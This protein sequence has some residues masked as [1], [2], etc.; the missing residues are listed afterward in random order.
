MEVSQVVQLA[1][2]FQRHSKAIEPK[3]S[4]LVGVLQNNSQQPSQ[5]PVAEPLRDLNIALK[6][7]PTS[8]LSML[9]LRVL[10][11]L[12]VAELIGKRGRAWLK[13]KIQGTTYD[14]A[15]TF[16]TVQQA[17]QKI[18][19][20][21]RLLNE[22]K[23][24]ASKVGFSNGQAL[25]AP[26]PYVFNVIFQED[27]AINNVSDWKKTAT[28]WEF[29]IAG[30]AGVAGEKAEDVAVVG[31]QNGS[32]IFTLS[33][34]PIVT[35]LLATI[36]KHIASIANDYLDIQLKRQQLE[37]SNMYTKVMRDEFNRLESERRDNGKTKI[38]DSIKEL[39]PTAKPE[40]LAKLEKA[41]DRH[42]KFSE[43]G[44]EVDFILPPALAEDADDYD[45]DLAQTVD[46]VREL[47][48]E[49]RGELE[50]TKLLTHVEDDEDA[51]D[52][53]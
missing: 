38:M 15:T 47:I 52:D 49:Y 21:K 20:A 17:H 27:V 26:T 22:F 41:I 46:D 9:Q 36:S 7:M 39:A 11:D 18:E 29:I 28:D 14:P 40:E 43:A 10:E 6:D 30:V 50:Q 25:D 37:R 35:K 8:E 33:A 13:R 16:N 2:W 1:E 4:A 34:A 53:D 5:Q 31:V 48:Q 23:T 12:G 24:A 42:V 44:G 51:F 32:T 45:E 19:E 3:Y